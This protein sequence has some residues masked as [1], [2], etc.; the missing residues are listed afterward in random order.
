[1]NLKIKKLLS[2]LLVVFCIFGLFPKV[3]ALVKSDMHYAKKI[4]RNFLKRRHD[5]TDPASYFRARAAILSG[6][7]CKIDDMRRGK[8]DTPEVIWFIRYGLLFIPE[9]SYEMCL[10]LEHTAY[11]LDIFENLKNMRLGYERLAIIYE[12]QRD[13]ED[14]RHSTDLSFYVDGM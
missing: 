5:Y 14:R 6:I 2:S 10:I 7:I 8:K 9:V 12:C 4:E 3:C 13:E 11:Y 1:M